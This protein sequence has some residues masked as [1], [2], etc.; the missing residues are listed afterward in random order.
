[1]TTGGF[2]RRYPESKV[3]KVYLL[4]FKKYMSSKRLQEDFWVGEKR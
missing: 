4:P 3:R 2:W 1:M